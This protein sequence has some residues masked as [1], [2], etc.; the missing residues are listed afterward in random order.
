MAEEEAAQIVE[1][2]YDALDRADHGTALNLARAA[3][4]SEGEDDPVLRFLAGIALLEL[5]L[6]EDAAGEL[7]RAVELDPDDP[8]FHARLAEAYFRGCRFDEAREEARRALECDESSPDAHQI[9]ALLLERQGKLD[10]AD[11]HLDRARSLDP[12]RFPKAVRLDR[13]TFEDELVRAGELLPEDFRKHLDRVA[14]TVE[15]IPSDSILLETSP[16]LD[17][18]LLGLFVGVALPDRTSFSPGG[19]LPPRILLFQ[20]NLERYAADADELRDEIAVTLYHELGHY[21][22]LDEEELGE[23]DL[24]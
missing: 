6:P 22:G 8:E 20:R 13:K 9:H 21:L 14:V 18:E 10:E 12:D 1:E 3:L 5:G 11:E 15:T 17:P 16:P 19:E 23:L 24:G 4:E 7:R 2:I